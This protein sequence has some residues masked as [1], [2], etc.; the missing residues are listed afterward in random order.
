MNI[1]TNLVLSTESAEI[2]KNFVKDSFSNNSYF[3]DNGHSRRYSS[4]TN[5]ETPISELAKEIRKDSFSRLGIDIFEEEPIYGIFLSVNTS[6][7][8]I[9]EHTDPTIEGHDHFRLNYMV[10]K[11]DFGG[12]PV[13]DGVPYSIKNLESWINIASEWKHRSTPVIGSSPRIVLSLGAYVKKETVQSVFN[14][15]N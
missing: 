13:I 1:K 11:P 8:S 2:I 10:S 4:L 14:S 12:M 3:I 9:Q 6:G 7:G 5:T 15:L